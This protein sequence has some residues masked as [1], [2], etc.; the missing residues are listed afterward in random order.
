MAGIPKA[1]RPQ[2]PTGTS[3]GGIACSTA[4]MQDP[5]QWFPASD[6]VTGSPAPST[7]D[8]GERPSPIFTPAG[9]HRRTFATL[10]K[11]PATRGFVVGAVAGIPRWH[12][13]GQTCRPTTE[14]SQAP[15]VPDSGSLG[16]AQVAE[17]E[18]RRKKSDDQELKHDPATRT[19][20]TQ[21]G[22]AVPT[23]CNQRWRS[24]RW[25]ARCRCR[26]AGR[27]QDWNDVPVRHSGGRKSSGWT[28]VIVSA[29]VT[30]T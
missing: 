23:A 15:A 3:R 20:P 11:C 6:S 27:C 1:G 18:G 24:G 30:A 26:L 17:L 28:G 4:T 14:R 13:R 22:P 21:H 2:E 9:R 16:P 12:A 10:L 5:W 29:A 7:I 19:P 8:V 25:W